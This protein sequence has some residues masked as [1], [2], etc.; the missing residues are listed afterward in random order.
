MEFKEQSPSDILWAEYEEA[1]ADFDDLSLGR[2]MCQTLG[3]M[4]GKI[5]RMSHPLSGTYRLCATL[6]HKRQ[7][8]LKRLASSPAAYM[9]SPC[10]RAPALPLLTR[11]VKEEGL[12]CSHCTTTLAP[13][14][15]IPEPVRTRLARWADAYHKVHGVAHW[16]DDRK[17]LCADYEQE[18]EAA[19]KKAEDLLGQAGQELCPMLLEHYPAIIWEDHDECLEVRP[20][21]IRPG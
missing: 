8:W 11:D 20:E 9:E 13:F 5:W 12:L 4:E 15:E 14:A 18:F 10:C 3:Q 19:A 1:L 7:I 2:W 21:D 6:G 17:R 16:D